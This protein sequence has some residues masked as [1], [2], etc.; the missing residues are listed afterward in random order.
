MVMMQ[1]PISDTPQPASPNHSNPSSPKTINHNLIDTK[2]HKYDNI[3]L[4]RPQPTKYD[5][6]LLSRF[7]DPDDNSHSDESKNRPIMFPKELTD[8]DTHAKFSIERLKQLTD[9]SINRLSPCEDSNQSSKYSLEANKYGNVS[10][11]MKTAL[12]MDTNLHHHAAQL[13]HHHQFIKYPS[14]S[15]ALDIE[16]IKLTRTI[17]NGKDLS[18][19]GFRIQLGGLHTNY[20]RSDTRSETSEELIVDG[21]DDG[22]S[23]EMAATSVCPVDLTRSITS[24]TESDKAACRKLAFSVENILDPTKFCSRKEKYTRHWPKGFDRDDHLEDDSE[25]QSAADINEMDQDECDDAMG[26]DMDDRASETDSKKDDSRGTSRGSSSDGKAQGNSSKPRRAR[27]AFTYEQLVSLENKFK[28]TRYLSV[29]ERLNLALSLS[30]TETQ[31][32]IWFQNRRTKWKKQNPGLDV[33]SPTVPPPSSSGA[34][35]PGYAGGLLYPHAVPYPPYGPYFHHL[36][37]H[38]LGHSHT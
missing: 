1:S 8:I 6:I 37:A 12:D 27:T 11:P 25:S 23:H 24:K 31:V 35:G 15:S 18:D 7:Q 19:F 21:N 5:G 17:T 4:E 32:K 9:H 30:L 16:R 13:A 20:A 3:R 28:T 10:P 29:C 14:N 22:S 34:F 26:S 36:S 38:H 33:N 2:F